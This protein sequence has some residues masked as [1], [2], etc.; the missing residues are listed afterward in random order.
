MLRRSPREGF[1]A[2]TALIADVLAL[3]THVG[4]TSNLIIDPELDS[5]YLMDTLITRL[6]R[7]VEDL[8]HARALGAG[9]ATRRAAT[10]EERIQ[11]PALVGETRAAV[12]AMDRGLR[13]AFDV[14]PGLR[15]R[16]EGAL[17]QSVAA[18]NQFLDTIEARLL[19][20]GPI[21]IAPAAYLTEG[22][23][24]IDA[25]FVLYDRTAPALDELLRAR[26]DRYWRKLYLVGSLVVVVLAVVGYLFVGFYQAVMRTVSSLDE[27]SRRMVGG[28]FGGA[29]QLDNRDELGRVVGSFNS[30]ASRC[31][32]SGRRPRRSGPG[33]PRPRPGCAR[34]RPARASRWRRR[35]TRSS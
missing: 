7:V 11:L 31:G 24:A 34:A 23:W 32:R 10:V 2:Q 26:I 4:D 25:A 6:L 9:I 3:V 8:G 5:Y 16:L 30:I 20:A 27:A 12:S 1:E 14:N 17:G 22:A 33:P 15:P 13:V 28:D 19:G 35:W 21:D 18:T 29:V